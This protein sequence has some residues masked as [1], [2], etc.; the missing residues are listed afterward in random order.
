MNSKFT[1]SS[2]SALGSSHETSV[3][4]GYCEPPLISKSIFVNSGSTQGCGV[5]VT[6][7]SAGSLWSDVTVAQFSMLAKIAPN[8]DSTAQ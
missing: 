2:L 4:S 8:F 7:A 5:I 3:Q 6:Q 1:C